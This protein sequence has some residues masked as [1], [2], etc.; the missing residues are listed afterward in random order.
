M[1]KSVLIYIEENILA[2]DL[3]KEK[4]K[5]FDIPNQKERL[6]NYL[7]SIGLGSNMITG[8]FAGGY[9]T[10]KVQ[11]LKQELDKI[12]GRKPKEYSKLKTAGG[13]IVGGIPI[14]G[15]FNTLDKIQKGYDLED[16]LF[17]LSQK[18][19]NKSKSTR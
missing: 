3:E 9:H 19:K 6:R 1:S 12:E 15:M 16:R 18:K 13:A 11:K 17:D 7:I 4:K 10:D 8:P 2:Y 5:D 14:V